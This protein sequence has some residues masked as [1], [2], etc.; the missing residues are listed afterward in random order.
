VGERKVHQEVPAEPRG[1]ILSGDEKWWAFL[2][3][4]TM[5]VKEMPR[6]ARKMDELLDWSKVDDAIR[7][8]ALSQIP[9]FACSKCTRSVPADMRFCVHCGA[10]PMSSRS[11]DMHV[12]LVKRLRNGEATETAK[13]LF[14]KISPDL[15]ADE[16][17][18]IF[19]EM[20]AMFIVEASKEQVAAWTNNLASRGIYSRAFRE[21][22]PS[23]PWIREVWESLMRGKTTRLVVWV[24][25]LFAFAVSFW[26][27]G[28]GI[29]LM[30]GLSFYVTKHVRWFRRR[31]EIDA[32]RLLT[33]SA[34]LDPD[35]MERA[36]HL[37][38]SVKDQNVRA[39][40]TTCLMEYYTLKQLISS[41][42][43]VFQG[44]S[45]LEDMLGRIL[46]HTLDLGERHVKM[47]GFLDANSPSVI[48]ERIRRMESVLDDDERAEER[49]AIQSGVE[50]H[51][52]SL[53]QVNRMVLLLP[54]IEDRLRA[55]STRMTATR[56]RLQ[57][58]PAKLAAIDE[59]VTL[60]SIV[61]EWD[62]EFQI[63][64]EV[65]EEIEVLTSR[66]VPV[67]RD[68]GCKR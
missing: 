64:A 54:R 15:V 33:A 40:V 47:R 9:G 46:S 1:E 27:L 5:E 49:A 26:S 66:Q 6:A 57:T 39:V 48:D 55:V 53:D 52:S 16:L 23:L 8:R 59:S 68:R 50:L 19:E 22:D 38:L 20:P 56:Y 7:P 12:I 18:S 45:S 30:I 65:Q 2:D 28:L 60:E 13:K 17:V 25:V 29:F 41:E 62:E 37:L 63:V 14:A 35:A 61:A 31:Y 34:G 43:L 42:G 32:Q 4:A 58:L 36:R 24:S 67:S 44:L 11:V 51:R 3:P 21:R 10:V